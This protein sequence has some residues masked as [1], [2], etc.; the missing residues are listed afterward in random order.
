MAGTGHGCLLALRGDRKGISMS[1]LDRLAADFVRERPDCI[2]LLVRLARK[3]KAAG[4]RR[5][6][7]KEL[8]ESAR[9]MLRKTDARRRRKHGP[10][11]LNNS[12]TSRLARILPRA[13]PDLRGAFEVRKLAS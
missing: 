8:F 12:L 4:E 2:H 5:L 1:R 13:Y 6:S 9:P 10:W 11:A 3:R 7:M